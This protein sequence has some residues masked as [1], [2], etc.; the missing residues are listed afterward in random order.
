MSTIY[1]TKQVSTG[2]SD[3]NGNPIQKLDLI[4]D[5]NK[6]MGGVD[7]N[8]AIVGHYSC[9]CKSYKWITKV[10]FHYLEE[11]LFNSFIICQKSGGRKRL[12][13]FKLAV[14]ASMLREAQVNVDFT[15]DVYNKYVGHHFPEL[16]LPTQSKENPQKKCVVCTKNKK[17]KE[18]CYQCKQCPN[19][20]GL[21]PASCF[22]LY[23]EQQMT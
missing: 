1:T 10:F 16:V 6:H 22:E 8:D 21:C 12:L 2:K 7:K 9:V 3:R 18:L 17:R 20:P 5:Y 14:I 23:H 15:E 11:S 13:D 4:N 19:H